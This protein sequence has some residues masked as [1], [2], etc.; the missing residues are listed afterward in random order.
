MTE[1]GDEDKLGRGT[2][3]RGQIS[4][5]LHQNHVF[6]VRPHQT[7]LLPDFLAYVTQSPYGRSYFFR[8]SHRTTNLAC[9]NRSKLSAFLVPLP[10]LDE[11]RRVVE[12]LSA[13]D[14]RIDA[15]RRRLAALEDL[16]RTLLHGLMTG[17]LR[18]DDPAVAREAA[19]LSLPLAPAE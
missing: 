6:A 2:V 1:G 15:E 19:Q 5:C 4:P 9:I 8:V 17:A 13:I 3:W 11:Q 12:I 14:A 16:Y 10:P 18:V 7:E